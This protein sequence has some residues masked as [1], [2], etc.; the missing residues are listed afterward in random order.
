[1]TAGD[2]TAVLAPLA[3][4]GLAAV[5]LFAG[6]V[7]D[8]EMIPR[9]EWLSLAGGVSV[10]YV[11]VHV[12]PEIQV[13]S[14]TVRDAALLPW[15]EHHVYL[16]ALVGFGSF[17]GLEQFVR[18]TGESDRERD[19][20]DWGPGVFWLHVGSFAAYNALIGYLLVHHETSGVLSLL[21]YVVAMA[22]HFVVN[23]YGLREHHGRAYHDRGRWLLAAAVLCGVGIG[24]LTEVSELLTA[25][26]FALLGG[27]VILNV[28]K[29]ELP[30]ERRSRFRAFAVGAGGYAAV[31]L[32]V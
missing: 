10:S 24:L 16:L 3:A 18:A 28:I 6:H 20:P 22:L 15:L 25:A 9:S 23:D 5:H 30:N 7:G 11:F 12:L 14:R 29:E 26:L 27:G 2:P 19:T 21:L 1:M 8:F 4:V 31:L 13:A 32:S 17:Y